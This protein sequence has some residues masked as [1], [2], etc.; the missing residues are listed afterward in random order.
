MPAL[1]DKLYQI[2]CNVDYRDA[3]RCLQLLETD[4]RITSAKSYLDLSKYILTFALKKTHEAQDYF[5][6]LMNRHPTEAIKLCVTKWYP[7]TVSLFSHSLEELI[8]RP[9][10]ANR[11]AGF[12]GVGPI[13][14][15]KAVVAEKLINDPRVH[16][17]NSQTSLLSTIAAIATAHLD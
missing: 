4:P 11:D 9:D 3:N 7:G 14:C 2:V 8:K 10:D 1:C 6:S 12:A 5:G 15:D 16:F 13:Y 17:Y